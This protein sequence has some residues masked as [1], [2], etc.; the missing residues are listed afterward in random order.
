M[1]NKTYRL[2]KDLPFAKAGEIFKR[3]TFKSEDGLSDYD[4][5]EICKLKNGEVN[6]TAFGIKRNYFTDNLGDWFEEIKSFE[7][8]DEFEMGFWDIVYH[9][10]DGFYTWHMSSDEFEDSY[11]DNLKH[12]MAIGWAFETEKEAE[13][14]LE[15]LKARAILIQDTKGFKPDWTD[16]RQWK[17]S[18]AYNHIDQSFYFSSMFRRNTGDIY[19]GSEDDL[20]YSLKAHEKEWKI[21]LGVE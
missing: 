13:K 9:I 20:K 8:P 18:V 1:S 16:E 12:H 19:F 2:L 17:Y 15:W 14:H 21:Y 5:F 10:D 11:E 7:V 6:E 3:H 4:Y